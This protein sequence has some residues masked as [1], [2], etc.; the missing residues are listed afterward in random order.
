MQT[1]AVIVAILLAAIG[2]LLV[3]RSKVRHIWRG[4]CPEC[5]RIVYLPLRLC[6]LCGAS[7]E[8]GEN[9]TAIALGRVTVVRRK[10]ALLRL[11]VLLIVLACLS[12][13]VAWLLS[14]DPSLLAS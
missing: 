13:L 3:H 6:P 7:F 4:R 10:R 5:Q 2:M 11:G 9:R 1:V 12:L 14:V 8:R